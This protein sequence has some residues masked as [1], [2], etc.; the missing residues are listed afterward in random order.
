MPSESPDRG[1]RP[2]GRPRQRHTGAGKDRRRGSPNPGRTE[3]GEANVTRPRPELLH[4]ARRVRHRRRP[5]PRLHEWMFGGGASCSA[6]QAAAAASTTPSRSNSFPG[7]A[8]RSWVPAS[9]ARP[10]GTRTRSG[11]GGGVPTRPSTRRSSS[12]PITRTR[13]SRWRR[14][15]VPLRRRDACRGAGDGPRSSRRPGRRPRRT[16]HTYCSSP[17]IAAAGRSTSYEGRTPSRSCG[18]RVEMSS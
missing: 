10:D 8:P 5:E 7:S 9:S 13:R 2:S 3:G 11:A 1:S 4:L 12:S 17:G 14:H 16:P 18:R 15:D 6:G